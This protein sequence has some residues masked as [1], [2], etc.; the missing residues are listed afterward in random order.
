MYRHMMGLYSTIS[1][2][3]HLDS[4]GQTVL[5]QA[6]R[7]GA[8]TVLELLP[9]RL[10]RDMFNHEGNAL[11]KEGFERHDSLMLAISAGS[12]DIV[13]RLLHQRVDHGRMHEATCCVAVYIA[14]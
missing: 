4:A 9:H 13:D 11:E 10:L 7:S 5:D 8:A 6:I 12:F 1:L 3:D 2:R 14:S